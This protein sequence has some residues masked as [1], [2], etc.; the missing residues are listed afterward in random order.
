[1][2]Q[3]RK[4]GRANVFMKAQL[5]CGGKSRDVKLRN[6]SAEGAL[7]EGDDLPVEGTELIFRKGDI[8]A[9]AKIAWV[10]HHRA[11]VSFDVHLNK[12]LLMRH[13]PRPRATSPTRFE[14]R[15]AIVKSDLSPE[16]RIATEN[17]VWSNP[18]ERQKR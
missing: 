11:G 7:V 4:A 9:P 2:N 6:L 18:I 3:N 5:E 13:V 14:G 16:E 17:W 12:E 8:K 10:S 15:P 1:M